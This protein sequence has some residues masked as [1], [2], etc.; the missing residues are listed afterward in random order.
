MRIGRTMA[1]TTTAVVIALG[2]GCGGD[3][4]GAS[5][6]ASGGAEGAAADDAGASVAGAGDPAGGATPSGGGTI[7]L[8]GESIELVE[9]LCYLEPQDA[10][11]GGGK[12]LFVG[13]GFGVDAD[14]QDVMI[15]VSRYDQDSTFAGDDVSVII[16]EAMSDD[17]LG[18]SSISPAGTVTVDGATLRGD[19]ITL[20]NDIDGSEHPV[21]FE[22]TC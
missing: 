14:G 20:V 6:P 9:T 19:G 3:D 13:Q 15:D 22:I 10:A 16:G 7:V 1:A 21:S 4:D 8:G 17:V 18:L 2:A 12:I 5:A 11:A